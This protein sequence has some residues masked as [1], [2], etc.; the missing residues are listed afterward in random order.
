MTVTPLILGQQAPSATTL[1]TLYTAPSNVKVTG[2]T[3]VVAN[4][5]STDDTFRIAFRKNGAAISNEQYVSY[6]AP[7]VGNDTICFTIGYTM[8]PGDVI[9]VYST[10]GTLSF[11]AFGV[12]ES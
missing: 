6:D 7:C 10:N 9:S 1:T 2:S 3:I 4:R 12:E 5:S 11:T 8:A